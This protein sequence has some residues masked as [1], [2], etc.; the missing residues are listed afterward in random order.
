M[1]NFDYFSTLILCVWLQF[2]N[3]VKFMHQGEGHI[4]VKVNIKFYVDHT[5]CKGVVCIRLNAFLFLYYLDKG[6]LYFTLRKLE[7]STQVGIK[8]D[9]FLQCQFSFFNFLFPKV[10][11]KNVPSVKNFVTLI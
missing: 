8:S 6:Q 5:L 3:K 10:K 4:K 11:F 1:S 9:F 7:Y 2:I